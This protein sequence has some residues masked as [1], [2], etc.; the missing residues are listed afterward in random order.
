VTGTTPEAIDVIVL[1]HGHADHYGGLMDPATG[2]SRFP[3][4]E[5]VMRAA[6]STSG[7]IRT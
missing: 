2:R 5:V 4:A 6:S 3:N 1:T 7:R